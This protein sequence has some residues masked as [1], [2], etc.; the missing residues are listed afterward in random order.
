MKRDKFTRRSF[1]TYS[2][3]AAASIMAACAAPAV[4]SAAE[5]QAPAATT[6]A[7]ALASA[8]AAPITI[9]W[10]TQRVG[11]NLSEQK[12]VDDF[13]NSQSNIVVQ[14]TYKPDYQDLAASIAA[15]TPPNTAEFD[16]FLVA[17]WAAQGKLADLSGRASAADISAGQ[18][19]PFAWDEASYKGKLWAL[20]MDT[21][22]RG[23]FYNVDLFKQVGLDPK[24]PPRTIDELD[25]AARELTVK[26]AHTFSRVGYSPWWNQSFHYAVCLEFAG[27]SFDKMYDKATNKC[28]A[29]AQSNVE[30][31][32]WIKRYA[33]SYNVQD[34]DA[35]GS[36]F[37]SDANDPVFLGQIAMI[38][39]IDTPIAYIKQFKPDMDYDIMAMP[40]PTGPA[41][42]MAGGWSEILPKGASSQDQGFQFLTYFAGKTGQLIYCLGE[43]LIPTNVEAASDPGFTADPKHAKMMSFLKTAVN[44]PAI[45]AGEVLWNSLWDAQWAVV[46][47]KVTPKAALDEVVRKTNAE[48][49][50]YP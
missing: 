9:D 47:D 36:T 23:I 31:F 16:R 3:L 49:A 39:V 37:G 11:V 13:N 7:L 8:E 18:Y 27:P 4:A 22:T 17:S 19:W 10:W 43:M 15:G 50:K 40:G 48:L 42:C 44:R 41:P 14:I 1:L 12:V 25:N 34:M 29:N 35:F 38:A 45:P 20:P 24:H 32:T 46:Y 26:K 21:D 33:R 6:P 2:G 28:T 5:S 30:A